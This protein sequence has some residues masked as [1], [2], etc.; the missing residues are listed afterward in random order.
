LAVSYLYG[1]Y[2]EGTV[3][4]LVTHLANGTS[5]DLAFLRTIGMN[6]LS[7]QLEFEKYIKTKYNWISFF[8]DTF[9]I[10]IGLA[11]MIVFLYFLKRRHT[12]KTLKQWEL[13]EEGIKRL[14]EFSND[15]AQD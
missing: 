11:F 7:F 6:Y 2:G 15:Q 3:K 13:E 1:E 14:D 8:G 12:R 5:I 4:E 10:W 9:L